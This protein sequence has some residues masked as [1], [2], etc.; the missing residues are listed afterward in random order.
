MKTLTE[1]KGTKKAVLAFGRMN[2]PTNGHEKLIDTVIDISKKNN[3]KPFVFISHTQDAKKN[4]LTSNQ[5]MKYILL[6][7]PHAEGVVINNPSIRTPF[8]AIKYLEK[9]GYRDLILVTGDDRVKE[10]KKS[11]TPYINH[12]DPNKSFD[13]ISFK[14]ISAGKRDPDSE[15]VTGI[16]ASK[17]RQAVIDKDLKTFK[18]GV[19]SHL[20]DKYTKEMFNE[21][22]KAMHI[23]EMVEEIQRLNTSMNI[24]RKNMPQIQSK[25]IDNFLEF[26]SS[27]GISVSNRTIS[28][29]SL[30]PIQ[31]EID[32]DKVRDKY[33]DFINGNESPKPF[34]VS[35]DNYILDGHHQLYALKIIDNFK[36]I[37]CFQVSINMRELLKLANNF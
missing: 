1:I 13:L 11:I 20:S 16:S 22:K 5:K 32:L 15:G 27:K 3:A 19:P 37:P 25:N 12:P 7:I 8:D 29:D 10:Y 4:P 30:K 36:K 31:N 23:V 17:M 28:I 9:N 18:S 14:V 24:S 6:G 26:L 34:I 33:E 35:Y 2:P 21:I